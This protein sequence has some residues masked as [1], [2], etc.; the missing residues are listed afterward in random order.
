MSDMIGARYEMDFL[1]TFWS[2]ERA[3]EPILLRNY[4]PAL[5]RA[6]AIAARLQGDDDA[7]VTISLDE[8]LDHNRAWLVGMYGIGWLREFRGEVDHLRRIKADPK[9]EMARGRYP[10]MRDFIKDMMD[11][12]VRRKLDLK[13]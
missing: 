10:L 11:T 4:W 13:N 7:Q 5:G 3:Q 9:E 8:L 6:L 12:W 2:D 1:D